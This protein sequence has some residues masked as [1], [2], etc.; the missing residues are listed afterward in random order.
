MG[1]MQVAELPSGRSTEV[2]VAAA[3]AA[4]IALA[5]SV[6]VAMGIG[7]GIGTPGMTPVA[8]LAGGGG[9][10]PSSM[11]SLL[12]S[13]IIG[14]LPLRFP[15]PRPVGSF[16]FYGKEKKRGKNVHRKKKSSKK[17]V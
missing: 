11:P 9:A 10:C 16:C 3:S 13:S 4:D 8:M 15:R 12:S 7:T 14:T 17:F 1:I 2:W 6:G 5:P